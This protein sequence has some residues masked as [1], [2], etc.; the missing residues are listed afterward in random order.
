MYAIIEDGGSQFRVEEGQEVVLDYRDIPAGESI[1]FDRVML[2]RSDEGL[3]IGKPYVSSARVTGEVLQVAQGPKLTVGKFRRR[4]NSRRRT[5]H[6]QLH[7]RVRI[8]KI[9]IG[10]TPEPG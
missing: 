2:L 4:K 1:Q 6:R 8:D 3:T 9:E 10:G 5:G 7:T